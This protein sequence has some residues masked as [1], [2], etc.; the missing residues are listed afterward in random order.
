MKYDKPLLAVLLG[1]IVMFPLEIYTQVF[2]Y[3]GL[4]KLSAF[5]LTSSLMVM[6]P[7]WWIGLMTGPA[8]GGLATLL[9]Y[10]STKRL[11]SD[12][13][14]IKGAGIGAI[15]YGLIEVIMGIMGDNPAVQQPTTGHFVHA[16]GGLWAGAVAGF[17]VK[18]YLLKTDDVTTKIRIRRFSIVPAPTLKRE[19]K[20]KRVRFVK[21]KKL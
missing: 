16:S 21:P 14:P 20:K 7:N 11:G 19:H 5:E 6:K 3:T 4:A 13:L 1:I 12:Y 15:N 18:R 8:V 10:Y 17:L 2:K 9:I